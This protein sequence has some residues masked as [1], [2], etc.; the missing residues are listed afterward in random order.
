[1]IGAYRKYVNQIIIPNGVTEIGAYA[2]KGCSGL[3]DITIPEGVTE[4]GPGA[5]YDCTGLTSITIPK[6]VT[7]IE[8]G[9]FYRCS[10]LTAIETPSSVTAIG[11][12]AF[13][14]CSG[15]TD[16]TI[17]EG[18]TEIG[19]GA[20]CRYSGFFHHHSQG[21]YN[22]VWHS[23][24]AAVWGPLPFPRTSQKLVLMHSRAAAVWLISPFPRASQNWTGSILS[25][26]Q[27]TSITI[28]KGVTY[29]GHDAFYG[30]TGRLP[31]RFPIASHLLMMKHS[32]T[33]P[34]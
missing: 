3:T 9:A 31:S 12:N 34:V 6:G 26:Q 27:L 30:C 21:R 17:P 15:L 25:L 20:F 18:V 28:P 29:I 4:I 2:F 33:A 10:G 22:W 19:P 8:E 23:R 24:A 11:P 7:S 1:M 16:I 14:G 5:F 13:G 32:L